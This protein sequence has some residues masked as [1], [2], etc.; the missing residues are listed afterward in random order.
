MAGQV[1]PAK[2]L[3]TAA[4]WL[5]AQPAVR[6]VESLPARVAHTSSWPHWVH[7]ALL[8]TLLGDGL[9][10]PWSHQREAMDL[11]RSG[12]HV[13]LSTGT[14]SGKSL[15]YL[16]PGLSAVLEGLD[17]PTGRGATVLYLSPTKALAADQRARVESWA[18]PGVRVAT[19]DGDTPTE[20][21]RWIRD[22]AHVVLTNP[23]SLHHS[24]LPGHAHWRAFFRALTMV[25][26]AITLIALVATLL[27]K[28]TP[29]LIVDQHEI[30]RGHRRWRRHRCCDRI[31]GG[32]TEGRRCRRR[33]RQTSSAQDQRAK[34]DFLGSSHE[35]GTRRW[36]EIHSTWVDTARIPI[37][38]RRSISAS[39]C[40]IESS[41]PMRTR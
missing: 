32:Q 1:L 6:H 41:G 21:R 16:V 40:S 19:H 11:A 23:D 39:A 9:A 2:D 34:Q 38:A 17:A 31:R 29:G 14:A 15:G 36:M 30:F 22:H 12:H 24:V 28:H 37:A 18:V 27:G 26:V 20:E 3:P 13:V 8:A 33:R 4:D 5:T 35:C 7:P 25:V 10:A